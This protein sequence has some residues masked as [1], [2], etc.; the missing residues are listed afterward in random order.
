MEK[1]IYKKL[2]EKDV[3]ILASFADHQDFKTFIKVLDL[4]QKIKAVNTIASS[5]NHETT[6]L[7]R[8]QIQGA[9]FFPEFAQFCK[10]QL[11]KRKSS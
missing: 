4:Y 7:N 10:E 2:T 5:P 6:V 8:G 3:A 9:N 11:Q 1:S